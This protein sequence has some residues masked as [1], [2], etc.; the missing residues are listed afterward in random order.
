MCSI[1]ICVPQTYQAYIS[2]Y[3]SFS[4]NL[5]YQINLFETQKTLWISV[6]SIESN[7]TFFYDLTLIR[8]VKCFW[9]EEESIWRYIFGKT[10]QGSNWLQDFLGLRFVKDGLRGRWSVAHDLIRTARVKFSVYFFINFPHLLNKSSALSLQT[11]QNGQT[12]SNNSSVVADKLFERVWPFC[13]VG[14]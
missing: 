13:G 14:A 2:L 6:I 4:I 8:L 11:P 5:L 10:T 9:G 12:H 7:K 1:N 3:D